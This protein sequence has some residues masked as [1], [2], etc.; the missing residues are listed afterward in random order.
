MCVCVLEVCTARD[1]PVADGV[2]QRLNHVSAAAG[3]CT[4][5]SS[6]LCSSEPKI[7]IGMWK[8]T[9]RR[10]GGGGGSGGSGGLE[11]EEGKGEGKGR[12]RKGER[13][14]VDKR[15]HACIKHWRFLFSS[16]DLSL[17]FF[18]TFLVFLC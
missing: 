9:L 14:W 17:V 6:M 2:R 8:L 5:L 1:S 18:F 10:E 15:C 16:P 11:G 13:G 3:A 4:V 7:Q 12:G